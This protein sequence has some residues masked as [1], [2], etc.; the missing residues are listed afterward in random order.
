MHDV[1]GTEPGRGQCRRHAPVIAGAA[2]LG[3]VDTAGGCE[4]A[5]MFARWVVGEFLPESIYLGELADVLPTEVAE[6]VAT[7][8][9]IATG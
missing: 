1:A 4:D 3:L 5:G 2:R 8:V 6:R 7:V 9:S